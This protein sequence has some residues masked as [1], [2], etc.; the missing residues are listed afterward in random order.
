MHVVFTANVL[1]QTMCNNFKA[2]TAAVVDFAR[3]PPL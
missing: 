3:F 2:G 1:L